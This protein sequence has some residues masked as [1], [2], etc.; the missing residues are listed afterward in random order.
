MLSQILDCPIKSGNDRYGWGNDRYGS[1]NEIDGSVN[2]RYGGRRVIFSFNPWIK[3]R[4]FA[5]VS[6]G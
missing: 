2:N 1:G 3:K 5:L 4:N 6:I